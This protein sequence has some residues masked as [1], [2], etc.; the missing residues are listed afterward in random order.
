M[1]L[2]RMQ[3]KLLALFV[4]VGFLWLITVQWGAP[5]VPSSF[6]NPFSNHD[7]TSGISDEKAAPSAKAPL[8][9]PTKATSPDKE[10][11]PSPAAVKSTKPTQKASKPKETPKH[12]APLLV[13]S[14]ITPHTTD[15]PKEPASPKATSIPDKADPSNNTLILTETFKPPTLENK[16][17]FWKVF[18]KLLDASKPGCDPPS[19]QG[20]AET[21]GYDKLVVSEH[22][23]ERADV[24]FMPDQSVVKM[25]KAHENFVAGLQAGTLEMV[26]NPGTRG[27]VTTAGGPY[28]PVF[29]ISLRMLRRT[30]TTLPMEVFLA[31]K[32]EYEE[33]ICDE[34]FPELNAKCVVL[35]DI[36]EAVPHSLD[37]THYQYKV[38]AMIFS[39]FEEVL[40]L[41]SD[42]FTLHDADELFTSEP[43]TNHG[44]VSW[45][46]FWASSASPLY[47][48]ISSQPVP[49]MSLRQSTESG[50][51]LLNKKTHSKSLLLA[52][53][54]NYFRRHYYVLFSQGAPGEGDKE[55]FLAAAN[56]L[57]ETFYATSENVRPIGHMKH[58]GKFSGSAMVQ[59]DPIQD[60]NL[61]QNGIWRIKNESAAPQPRPFFLHVNFPR[62]N[63]TKVFDYDEHTRNFQG[64]EQRIWQSEK[65]IKEK[66]GKDIEK[67]IWQEVKYV[68]CELE[69][70]FETFKGEK[71]L[72]EKA[73]K[74][75]QGLFGKT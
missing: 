47:Y 59:Y 48:N 39:S 52:T 70:K 15:L 8:A 69:D 35:S 57:N 24:L 29:V 32:K 7:T 22:P 56:A 14:T 44:L 66:F 34:V 33:Y 55:T 41:D 42:A 53:Y 17:A 30:G 21:I 54:Y 28:L 9:V 51:L 11:K 2:P 58:D 73:T 27:L 65:D 4:I 63:P 20:T 25:K 61:T 60:Y 40:F 62:L 67:E 71:G 64:K 1:F 36:L 38:F 37:I 12:K 23:S 26:Y 5:S 68:S 46:D 31:D 16:I 43:F 6:S 75:Y 13:V 18:E 49:P 45:P 74:H 72:C 10:P 3:S 19:R 50:E